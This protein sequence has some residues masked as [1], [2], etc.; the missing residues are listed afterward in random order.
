M[1]FSETRLQGA[2]TVDLEPMQDDRGFFAR[3]FCARE[4]Q[5]HGLQGCVAQCNVSFNA[6]KGTIRGLHFAVE[7]SAEAKLVRCTRGAI[8]DVI[9]DLRPDSPTHLEHVAFDLSAE[10]RRA[11]YIPAGFAHGFQTVTDAAEVFYQMS[12]P[13]VAVV[14]RAYRWDDPAFGIAW[15]LPVSV[16]SSRDAQAPY[17]GEGAP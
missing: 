4:F 5:E 1:R 16:L 11:I 12:E 13:Y 10:N 7:P 6:I 8:W 17:L 9:V 15:P 3:S 14:Q 2:Y